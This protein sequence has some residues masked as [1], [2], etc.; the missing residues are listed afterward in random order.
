MTDQHVLEILNDLLAAMEKSPYARLGETGA[1]VSTVG[2]EEYDVVRRVL[3]EEKQYAAELADLLIELGG[4]PVAFG[5]PDFQAGCLHFLEA[6]FLL[7]EVLRW[8]QP[9]LAKCE[10]ALE[11]LC[12][13]ARAYLLVSKIAAAHR[14]HIVLLGEIIARTGSSKV[15]IL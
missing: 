10:S 3:Q 13:S 15:E 4:V 11:E 14:D 2:T 1:F 7:R 9:V 8:K 5:A 6:P 12:T